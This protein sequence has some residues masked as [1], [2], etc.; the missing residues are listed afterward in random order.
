MTASIF[1]RIKF[2]LDIALDVRCLV[3]FT[4]PKK[5]MFS[6]LL[7]VLSSDRPT[8]FQDQFKNIQYL[9]HVI[10]YATSAYNIHVGFNNAHI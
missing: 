2:L 1:L 5:S 3:F 8:N 7:G 6:R 9:I 10:K 4:V